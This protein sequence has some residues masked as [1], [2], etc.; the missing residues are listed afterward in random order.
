[1]SIFLFILCIDKQ[2][3]TFNTFILILKLEFSHQHLKCKQKYCIHSLLCEQKLVS[4]TVFPNYFLCFYQRKLAKQHVNNIWGM[5]KVS[6]ISFKCLGIYASQKNF[7]NY[8]FILIIKPVHY[9]FNFSFLL[10]HY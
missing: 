6:W 1:M 3:R 10:H 2:L 9:V 7:D 4:K 8:F 5:Y